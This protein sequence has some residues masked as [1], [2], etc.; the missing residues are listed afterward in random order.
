MGNWKLSSLDKKDRFRCRKLEK[1]A[2]ELLD[3]IAIS[4]AIA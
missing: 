3:I 1:P 4:L 2:D